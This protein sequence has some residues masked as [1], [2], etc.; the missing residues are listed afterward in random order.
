[1]LAIY[2]GSDGSTDDTDTRAARHASAR[3]HL[4]AFG[5]R[6][7]KASVLNDLLDEVREEIVVF[8]DANTV[9]RADAVRILVRHFAD[10]TVGAVSGELQLQAA[11][12]GDRPQTSY[13]RLETAL[14]RGESR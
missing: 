6:R 4:F 5:E 12:A 14:Q 13:W 9:F 2:I 10:P 1:R 3:V 8:T 11:G 7:G